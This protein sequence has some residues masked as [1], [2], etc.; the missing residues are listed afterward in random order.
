MLHDF[1]RSQV[2]RKG[3]FASLTPNVKRQIIAKAKDSGR[4]GWRRRAV[5]LATESHAGRM[6]CEESVRR[7][8]REAGLVYRRLRVKPILK[9]HHI[10]VR[11]QW[12]KNWVKKPATFWKQFLFSD[13]KLFR[14]RR[15]PHKQNDGLWMDILDVTNPDSE[16]LYSQ[17]PD[18]S[19][20]VNVWAAAGFYGKAKLCI[21]TGSN[22]AKFYTQ[23]IVRQHVKPFFQA[24]RQVKM[25]Q[26]DGSGVHTA[27]ECMQYLDRWIGKGKWTVPPPAPCKKVGADGKVLKEKVVVCKNGQIRHYAVDAEVCHC[28]IPSEFFHPARS[29][30]MAIAEHFWAWMERWLNKQQP[31]S[32]EKEFEEMVHRAWAALP[33]DYIQKL[34]SGIPKRLQAL[35]AAKGKHT[36]Y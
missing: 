21:I 28:K 35:V 13:E 31:A 33:V 32:N 22:D 16:Q 15:Q 8:L 25:F 10:A 23:A 1:P 12:G 30:D 9:P 34:V 11:L 3:K 7:V 36:K 6:V 14:M 5:A 24:H 2:R 4:P 19:V 27:R 26:Q 18:D 17:Q 20:R 29:P